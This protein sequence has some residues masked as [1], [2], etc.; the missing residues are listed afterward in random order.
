MANREDL[1]GLPEPPPGGTGVWTPPMTQAQFPP[2]IEIK[3]FFRLPEEQVEMEHFIMAPVRLGRASSALF[4]FQAYLRNKIKHEDHSDDVY[5]ALEEVES[6][7]RD[8]LL[9]SGVDLDW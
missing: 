6:V 9:E 7:F 5:E 1:E 2:G 8:E 3:R 4:N